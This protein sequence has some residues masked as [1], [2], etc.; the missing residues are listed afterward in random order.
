[1]AT[2]LVYYMRPHRTDSEH[3]D[4]RRDSTIVEA[5]DDTSLEAAIVAT[6]GD[7]VLSIETFEVLST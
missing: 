7:T 5:A 4:G 2:Y 3:K 6:T 1:M